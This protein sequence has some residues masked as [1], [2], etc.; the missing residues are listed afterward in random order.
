MVLP[1]DFL[2]ELKCTSLAYYIISL[3]RFLLNSRASNAS[4]FEENSLRPTLM[5]FELKSIFLIAFLPSGSSAESI[6]CKI[7]RSVRRCLVD[8]FSLPSK[9]DADI[10]VLLAAPSKRRL[11]LSSL[12]TIKTDFRFLLFCKSNK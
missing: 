10:L 4:V 2:N 3:T 9:F 6:C 1:T 11:S 8:F 12:V 5:A 7:Y